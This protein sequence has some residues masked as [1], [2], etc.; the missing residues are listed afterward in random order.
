[1][2]TFVSEVKTEGYGYLCYDESGNFTGVKD[3]HDGA[4]KYTLDY[5]HIMNESDTEKYTNFQNAVKGHAAEAIEYTKNK[6]SLCIS[7]LYSYCI[8]NV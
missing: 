7:L 1:M 6:K 2:R 4:A 3:S 8:E 5:H